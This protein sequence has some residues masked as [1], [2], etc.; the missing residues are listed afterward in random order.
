MTIQGISSWTKTM[1]RQGIANDAK[2]SLRFSAYF[3]S[4][5]ILHYPRTFVVDYFDDCAIYILFD[6]RFIKDIRL[7]P[8]CHHINRDNLAE[9]I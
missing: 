7:F 8:S 2:Y 4:L 5:Y 1:P 6:N 9:N 3:H